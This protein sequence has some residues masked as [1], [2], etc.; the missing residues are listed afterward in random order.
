M[1]AVLRLGLTLAVA[2]PSTNL[3]ATAEELTGEFAIRTPKGFYLTA[4]NN[5]DRATEPVVVTT[6]TSAGGWE[7]FKIEVQDPPSLH[8]KSFRTS[9]GHY[10]TAVGGG[11]RTTDVVHTD[12]TQAR[13]WEKFRVLD[14]SSG[15][16]APTYFAL[17]TINGHYLTAVGQGGKT[18]DALHS[19]A[20]E[21]KS[22]EHLRLVKCGDLGTD[23][24]Y[25]IIAPNDQVLTAVNGGGLDKGDTIVQGFGLGDAPN[26]PWSRFKLTRQP[27]GS[28][29]LQTANGVNYVTALGGGGQVQ[30][31]YP[32]DCG[33]VGAC[34]ASFS[35][36]F[37]T[38]ATEV[39][40][41]ERFKFIDQGNC[42]YAIQTTSGFFV[43][44][45]KDA[46]GTTLLTTR[47]SVISDNERFQLVMYG[48]AS[49]ISL[50]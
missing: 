13:E 3:S 41:W 18:Q 39:R 9:S 7:K 30:K 8:D 36:I 29:A 49:P 10:L 5:G 12:A 44:I 33:L 14:L 20:T 45:F 19:D 43:G 46:S 24:E 17:Q 4:V 11:G 32:P 2:S 25:S 37:H 16:V 34:I 40:S 21:I 27:D 50:H 31:Y 26:R 47:R 6:A 28:Y 22:W 42:K 15:G 35:T 1:K 38:D 48:L 23:Y